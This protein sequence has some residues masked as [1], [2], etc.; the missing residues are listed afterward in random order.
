MLTVKHINGDPIVVDR[1]T[2]ELWPAVSDFVT[3]YEIYLLI[4]DR[5]AFEDIVLISQAF[6]RSPE[7]FA[8]FME[9]LPTDRIWKSL[10]SADYLAAEWYVTKAWRYL[11]SRCKNKQPDEIV[12]ALRLD[13]SEA[14]PFSRDS[15]EVLRLLKPRH[16]YQ[17]RNDDH[18]LYRFSIEKKLHSGAAVGRCLIERNL[19]KLF[20]QHLR[21]ESYSSREMRDLAYLILQKQDLKVL[22]MF[23]RDY[24]CQSFRSYCL[25]TAR[26]MQRVHSK[27]FS[28]FSY[29]YKQL[30]RGILGDIYCI[31]VISEGKLLDE[32]SPKDIAELCKIGFRFCPQYVADHRRLDIAKSI[33]DKDALY[34]YNPYDASSAQ[35][36]ASRL[37]NI[38]T[39]MA[40]LF[41]EHCHRSIRLKSVSI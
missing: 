37:A 19:F 41:V 27:P 2:A 33:I 28:Q 17:S 8:T 38:D 23:S 36:M 22:L 14:E 39:A 3:D 18:P 4:D 25:A 40:K 21:R 13:M 6:L 7:A 31:N 20:H 35:V 15:E 26:T 9:N 1:N 32:F 11:A 24:L 34:Y 29:E 30:A 16:F 10:S 5:D 12:Q